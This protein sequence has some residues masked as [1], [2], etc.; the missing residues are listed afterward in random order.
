[1]VH[2]VLVCACLSACACVGGSEGGVVFQMCCGMGVGG[3][4]VGK[5]PIRCGMGMERSMYHV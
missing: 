3:E 4:G 2:I 1:M 5:Q